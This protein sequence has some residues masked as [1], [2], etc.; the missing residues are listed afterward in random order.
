MAIDT[1]PVARFPTERLKWYPMG[2]PAVGGGTFTGP[3]QVG[4][5][6]G[7]GWW[8]A[9]LIGMDLADD[10]EIRQMEALLGRAAFGVGLFIVE[11]V[12]EPL[13]PRPAP[14]SFDDETSFDD[15]TLFEGSAVT[16]VLV[17]DV[18]LRAT[19]YRIQCDVPLTGGE[20]FT[21]VHAV[22]GPRKYLIVGIDDVD[23]D[24]YTVWVMQPLRE[25]AVA[26]TPV[27]FD[28]PRCV[29]RL[30]DANGDAW[31]TIEP[32]WQAKTSLRFVEAFDRLE[33]G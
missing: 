31:P 32:G 25:A 17:D 33:M 24:I 18:P 14:V 28:R 5:F 26:G 6:S 22:H 11:R 29:M 3:G 8:C 13:R 20:K 19:T 9:A 7:G 1:F 16:A 10:A 4:E 2:V 30:E 23:G 12:V 15:D 27:D 21:I